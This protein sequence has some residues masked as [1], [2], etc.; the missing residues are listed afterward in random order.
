MA[1][2][3]KNSQNMFRTKKFFYRSILNKLLFTYNNKNLEKS[4][5]KNVKYVA[6]L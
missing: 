3:R 2:L 6:F 1:T 5:L 4:Y